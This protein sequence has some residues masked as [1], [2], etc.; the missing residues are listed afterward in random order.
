MT[1]RK[2]PRKPRLYV[3]GSSW[4]LVLTLRSVS[5]APW[6][7]HHRS[8]RASA[9]AAIEARAGIAATRE[10]V[11]IDGREGAVG[12]GAAHGTGKGES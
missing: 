5:L 2:P 4:I 3:T 6:L 10:D 11:H 1:W 7:S 12:D 9:A 8:Y